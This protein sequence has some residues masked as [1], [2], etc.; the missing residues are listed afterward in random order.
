MEKVELINKLLSIE[1]FVLEKN[2]FVIDDQ[3][4]KK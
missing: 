2:L 1:Q 4:Q 3:I